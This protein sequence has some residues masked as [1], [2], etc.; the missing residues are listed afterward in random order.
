MKKNAKRDGEGQPLDSGGVVGDRAGRRDK[1]RPDGT[2]LSADEVAGL[3][4]GAAGS[5]ANYTD[6][7][8]ILERPNPH[9]FFAENANDLFDKF[10]GK[11]AKVVGGDNRRNGPDRHVDGVQSQS[12]Y[13]QSG[14]NCINECFKGEKFRY[15]N[16]DGSPMQIEVPS[17]MYEGAVKA[18]EERIRRGQVKGVSDPG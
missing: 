9:G 11:D 13:C 16:P 18:M 10:A 15:F 12:K 14:L 1:E 7:V 17:D 5:G 8:G 4:V 6:T 2:P 3:G